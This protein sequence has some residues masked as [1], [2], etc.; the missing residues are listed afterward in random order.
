MNSN[1]A[2]SRPQRTVMLKHPEAKPKPT[3]LL[4]RAATSGS[5]MDGLAL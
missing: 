2:D 3:D 1:A 4:E 5:L